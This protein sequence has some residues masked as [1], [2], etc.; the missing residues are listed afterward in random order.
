MGRM[1]SPSRFKLTY[2]NKLATYDRITLFMKDG[3]AKAGI[4]MERDPV[5]W[6][7]LQQ[8]LDRRDFDAILLA[9]SGNV[10]DDPHQMFDSSQI[11][12]QGDNFMS[13]NSPELDAA[14]KAARGCVDEAQRTELWHKVHDILAED[15]PYT[16]MFTRKSTYF[17]NKRL[18]EYSGN[19]DG[20]ELLQARLLA[21][22]LVRANRAAEIFAVG[23]FPL[24]SYII[25]RLLLL[26]PTL[27][28]ITAVIFFMI[29]LSP[30]GIGASLLSAEG[31]MR[32]AERARACRIHEPALRPG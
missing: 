11:G 24:L 3:F 21:D 7:L 23:A 16:F 30:G 15:Q 25:R 32:P 26:P 31:N 4:I 27:I 9:W 12:D 1:A 29:A 13:Y 19:E 6:P 10:E 5:E 8:K 20:S 14:L 17:F 28:G 22:A 18:A 2:P